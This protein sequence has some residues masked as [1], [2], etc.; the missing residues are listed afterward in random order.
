MQTASSPP[1]SIRMQG[2]YP[3]KVGTGLF[4]TPKLPQA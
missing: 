1:K 4:V 2:V 3:N